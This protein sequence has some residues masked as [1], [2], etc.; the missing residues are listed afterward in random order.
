M[1]AS[2]VVATFVGLGDQPSGPKRA[3]ILRPV[4]QMVLFNR[5]SLLC[6]VTTVAA[7]ER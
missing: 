5:Q 7:T 4:C 3:L 2:P 6:L 1:G